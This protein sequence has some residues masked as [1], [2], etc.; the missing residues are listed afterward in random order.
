MTRKAKNPG[1]LPKSKA[2]KGPVPLHPLLSEF[3][4][5]WKERTPY[6][7]PGDWVFPSLRV[8]GKQP[9]VAN[10]LV[11]DHLRPDAVKAGILSSHRD[12]R[13]KLVD[14]DPRRFDFHNLRHKSRVVSHS[15]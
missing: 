1:S 2:S 15:Y 11:E 7:A 14:D 6:S 10:M 3:M 5:R 9:R 4:L 8:N 13:G 12:A